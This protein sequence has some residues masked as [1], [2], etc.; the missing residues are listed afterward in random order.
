[1]ADEEKTEETRVRWVQ[2][3]GRAEAIV[4]KIRDIVNEGV[5]KAED[6]L[7]NIFNILNSKVYHG[8]EEASRVQEEETSELKG[9]K[10]E[11]EDR[12]GEKAEKVKAEL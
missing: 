9:K 10:A 6:A 8:S 12:V 2:A 11:M 1:M 4:G 7:Y 5:G 3:Q